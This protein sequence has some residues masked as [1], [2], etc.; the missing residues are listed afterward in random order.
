MA[1]SK[2]EQVERLVRA[3]MARQ[4][5][6]QAND[7]VIKRAQFRSDSL[8][9]A[10]ADLRATIAKLIGDTSFKDAS[11]VLPAPAP[12]SEPGLGPQPELARTEG[13]I[14]VRVQTLLDGTPRFFDATEI[15]QAV[16]VGVD[17]VRTTLSKLYSRGL[18]ARRSAGEYCSLQHAHNIDAEVAP[19]PRRAR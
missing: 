3:L 4:A 16:G 12:L 19:R 11:A 15:A 5:E 13:T 6:L 14:L 17:V 2:V 1:S 8:R 7:E 10:V 18:I 9:A